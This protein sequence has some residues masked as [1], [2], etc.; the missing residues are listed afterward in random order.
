MLPITPGP[1]LKLTYRGYQALLSKAIG[2]NNSFRLTPTD[3]STGMFTHKDS[4]LL[5]LNVKRD[6]NLYL[7]ISTSLPV[8][9]LAIVSDMIFIQ[10]V[11][12]TRFILTITG[13][14]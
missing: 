7:Y 11:E 8:R 1:S 13:D 6:A 10:H 14:G 12:V 4:C 2:S 5:Q 9:D 3:D